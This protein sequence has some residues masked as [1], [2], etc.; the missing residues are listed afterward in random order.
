M[1]AG[2]FIDALGVVP[3]GIDQHAN[4][5]HGHAKGMIPSLGEMDVEGGHGLLASVS[6]KDGSQPE[7]AMPSF[8]QDHHNLQLRSPKPSG[9]KS[10][11]KARNRAINISVQLY[12]CARTSLTVNESANLKFVHTLE[13]LTT[14]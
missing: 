3:A 8:H 4:R 10:H 11:F 2:E 14:V 13:H 9:W 12:C 7:E 5:V 6:G 1:F